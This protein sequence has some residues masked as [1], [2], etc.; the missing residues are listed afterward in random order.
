MRLELSRSAA[1]AGLLAALT[2]R[3]FYGLAL[4][5]PEVMNAAW[6]TAPLGALMV[7]PVVWLMA[8]GRSRLMSSVLFLALAL[9]TK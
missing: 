7:L 2:A 6:L 3:T 5:A 1:T 4:D 8:K 9:G